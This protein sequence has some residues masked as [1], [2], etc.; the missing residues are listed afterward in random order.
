MPIIAP[1]PGPP[2]PWPP[3]ASPGQEPAPCWPLVTPPLLLHGPR[4]RPTPPWPRPTGAVCV[5]PIVWAR[6]PIPAPP[7]PLRPCA[8]ATGEAI[9]PPVNATAIISAD[10]LPICPSFVY[11]RGRLP[12]AER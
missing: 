5:G 2:R 3:P 7:W 8:N 12:P 10:I 9:I 4:P 11:R 1:L 6:Q